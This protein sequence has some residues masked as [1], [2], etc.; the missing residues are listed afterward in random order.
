MCIRD[1]PYGVGS[2]ACMY[3]RRDLLLLF[4]GT[5]GAGGRADETAGAEAGTESFSRE[6]PAYLEAADLLVE[7]ERA[8]YRKI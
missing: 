4:Q 1:R 5:Q 6:D 3:A 7:S 8:E 2:R